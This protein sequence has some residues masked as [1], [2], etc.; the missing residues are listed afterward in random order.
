MAFIFE[1]G[2]LRAAIRGSVQWGAIDNHLVV[3]VL[4]VVDRVRG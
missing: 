3:R 4:G 1:Q 2:L